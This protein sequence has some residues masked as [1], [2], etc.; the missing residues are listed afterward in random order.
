[1]TAMEERLVATRS[2]HNRIILYLLAALK[3]DAPRGVWTKGRAYAG[4]GGTAGRHVWQ[5]TVEQLGEPM[6]VA[7]LATADD[8]DRLCELL[9]DPAFAAMSPLIVAA[10]GQ[11]HEM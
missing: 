1:M 3:P 7:G 11:R 9:D 8:L 2:I 5:Q 6:V 4:R 10:W